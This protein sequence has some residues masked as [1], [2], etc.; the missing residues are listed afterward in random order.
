MVSRARTYGEGM[1]ALAR[2]GDSA[3]GA[4]RDRLSVLLVE[5]DD[6]D[7]LIVEDLLEGA[8]PGARLVRARTFAQALA[9]LEDD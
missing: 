7:A 9:K 2:P 3:T 5:D 4:T 8:L 6:G 1:D